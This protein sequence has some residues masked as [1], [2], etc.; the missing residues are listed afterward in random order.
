[1]A[2][3]AID[4]F[5][6]PRAGRRSQR[7]A[8]DTTGLTTA[9]VVE[10]LLDLSQSDDAE[11]AARAETLLDK[12]LEAAG[13]SLGL[14]SRAQLS[15]PQVLELIRDAIAAKRATEGRLLSSSDDD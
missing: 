6:R 4:L 10:H 5:G 8:V 11:T 9:D 1:M 3:G 7:L 12:R 15:R 14:M 2:K 13:L